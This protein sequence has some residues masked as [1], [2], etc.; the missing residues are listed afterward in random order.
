MFVKS[1]LFGLDVS[2]VTINNFIKLLLLTYVMKTGE[3]TLVTLHNCV[4]KI[5]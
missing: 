1:V 2:F 3:I 4:N 5:T